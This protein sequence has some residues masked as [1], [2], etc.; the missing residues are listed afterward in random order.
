MSNNFQAMVGINRQ[1]QHISGT[2][3]PTDPARFIQPDAFPSDKLIPMPREQSWR[4]QLR[5]PP[6]S[7]TRCDSAAR[8]WRRAASAW[9]RA[10]ALIRQLPANDPDIA[11]FGPTTFRLANGTT[12]SNPLSTHSPWPDDAARPPS[13]AARMV[14]GPIGTVRP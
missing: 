7:S 9:R 1:W 6:G 2:W 4:R 10:G 13:P 14:A 3:N 12:Q 11:R 8:T 5:S